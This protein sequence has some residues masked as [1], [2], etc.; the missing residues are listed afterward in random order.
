MARGKSKKQPTD[1]PTIEN[2]KARHSYTIDQTFEVGLKLHGSEVKSVREGNASIAEGFVR[3]YESPLQ[4]KIHN[5]TIGHYAPASAMN[6]DPLRTRVLL[7][8]KA[9]IRRMLKAADQKGTT[10][11]PLKLYFKNGYAKL[12]IGIA[13]GKGAS[14]KRQAIKEREQDLEIRRAMSTKVGWG[15]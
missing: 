2:R 6:H 12:L 14:D 9:E 11:V 15:R 1:Q 5:V 8:K 3:A 7:A 4:L 13:R 10:I